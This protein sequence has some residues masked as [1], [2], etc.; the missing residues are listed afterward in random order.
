VQTEKRGRAGWKA[1]AGDGT[2]AARRTTNWEKAEEKKRR[3]GKEKEAEKPIVVRE[4]KEICILS[5]CRLEV[6]GRV[7]SMEGER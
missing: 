7:R 5:N 4:T 2:E 1:I 3:D 6:R